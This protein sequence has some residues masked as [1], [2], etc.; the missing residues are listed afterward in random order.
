MFL[1][2]E[3]SH[4]IDV[5][6]NN[7]VSIMIAF[8]ISVFLFSGISIMISANTPGDITGL[9]LRTPLHFSWCV[10]NFKMIYI[11]WV[12]V[13]FFLNDEFLCFLLLSNLVKKILCQTLRRR[14][15]LGK[16]DLIRRTTYQFCIF[17][18]L[19]IRALAYRYVERWWYIIWNSLPAWKM[20]TLFS[21]IVFQVFEVLLT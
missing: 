9:T 14:A 11:T 10:L 21:Y 12:L 2:F 18:S 17:D 13:C 16:T 5:V 4:W 3:L 20:H 7:D 1:V 8:R 19:D 6:P 15:N